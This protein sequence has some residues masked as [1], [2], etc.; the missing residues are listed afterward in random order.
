MLPP[1]SCE[2]VTLSFKVVLSL[3]EDGAT[4]PEAVSKWA[5]E[6]NWMGGDAIVLSADTAEVRE[7]IDDFWCYGGCIKIPH[8][9]K[10]A[11]NWWLMHC[12]FCL[13]IRA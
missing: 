11:E 10:R 12:V 2:Y 1:P 4:V 13:E 9:L 3:R 8:V 6:C 5:D 7:R